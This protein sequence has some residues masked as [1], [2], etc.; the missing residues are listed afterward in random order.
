MR[1]TNRHKK[2]VWLGIMLLAACSVGPDYQRPRFWDENLNEIETEEISKKWYCVFGD[3][4][5][6][7]LEEEA[8]KNSPDVKVALAQMRQARY[9][10]N[11]KQTEFL[12]G[13]DIIGGY[14]YAY[15]PKYDELGDKTSFFKAGFDASWE[16]D[17]WGAGRRQNESYAAQYKAAISN[18]NNVLRSLTAELANDYVLLRVNQE[19]QRIVKYNLELQQD[20]L[21][22]VKD[23][24]KAGL[25]DETAL[26]QAEFAVQ[27]TKSQIP[28]LEYQEKYYQN[29]IAILSGKRP[30]DIVIS[31]KK[32]IVAKKFDF[33]LKKLKSIPLEN[34]RNRPDV[35]EAE[36]MLI[37]KNAEVGQA[38]A[39]MFPNVS[40]SAL[41]GWQ[42]HLIRNLGRGDYASY[43][44]NPAIN[45]PFLHWGKLINQVKMSKDIKEEYLYNYQKA[46][47]N[48]LQEVKNAVMAVV[49]EYDKNDAL[50]KAADN[51]QK[52]LGSMQIK[53][54]E[55]LIEFS[56][57]LSSEQN[58]LSAQ[59]NLVVSHG[60]IYEKIISFYKALGGGY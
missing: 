7:R 42:G 24:Y 28:D 51:M 6:N 47:L 13:V 9:M 54:Q 38:V 2:I 23:K 3:E 39:A 37:A 31:G 34:I 49:K 20:I 12:P 46:L 15:A 36:A 25:T 44:Y 26:N 8:L 10:F 17:I 19:R 1:K 11:I 21:N 58:L 40:V 27:T 29:A 41:L 45:M 22:T 57:L 18:V 60:A 48:A 56:D 16:I 43:G 52:V 30:E 14:N 59:D 50:Q 55:G 33:D 35:K 32:N 5:L 53:Y 4:E